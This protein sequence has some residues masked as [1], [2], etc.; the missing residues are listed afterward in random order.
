MSDK[1]LS[2][3]WIINSSEGKKICVYTEDPDIEKKFDKAGC[4]Y[5]SKQ[6]GSK[7]A[8]QYILDFGS[9]EHK[10]I[11]KILGLTKKDIYETKEDEEP[12]PR[13]KRKKKE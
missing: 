9:P 13:K 6:R 4:N 1:P 11:V 2:Q 3:Y 5:S 10:R 7:Y 12:K 8:L